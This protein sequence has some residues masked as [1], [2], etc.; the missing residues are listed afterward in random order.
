MRPY[1]MTDNK[2]LQPDMTVDLWAKRDNTT[3][4]RGKWRLA[5]WKR[6]KDSFVYAEGECSANYFNTAKDALAYGL[7]RY[8]EKGKIWPRN[9]Y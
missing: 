8:D 3:S 4:G 9:E 1:K 6:G 2:G 7:R 5:W